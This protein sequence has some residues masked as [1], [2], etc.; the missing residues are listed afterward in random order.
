MKPTCWVTR[1][2]CRPSALGRERSIQPGA[3]TSRGTTSARGM[4]R[5]SGPPNRRR[6]WLPRRLYD[7]PATP[8]YCGP[9][10]NG[11]L[12]KVQTIPSTSPDVGWTRCC[13]A[14]VPKR[15]RPYVA[16][17]GTSLL[18]RLGSG[19]GMLLMLLAL[20]GYFLASLPADRHPSNPDAAIASARPLKAI[21]N[22][23][24]GDW[25]LAHDP[26]LSPSERASASAS[27][28]ALADPKSLRVI[29][30]EMPEGEGEILRVELLR[31]EAWLQENRDQNTLWLQFDELGIKGWATI[32]AVHP[33]PSFA[34]R[35]KRTRTWSPAGSCTRRQCPM[36]WPSSTTPGAGRN[37]R[38]HREPSVL[39]RG[40]PGLRPGRPTAAWRTPARQWA[41][42]LR[43]LP[44]RPQYHR[45]RLQPRS[46]RRTRLPRWLQR[47]PGA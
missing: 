24:L 6:C 9:P 33:A 41:D 30:A 42:A 44:H 4:D 31:T 3:R 5:R 47:H 17:P 23:A 39:E 21:E 7:G 43:P 19:V 8:L 10:L 15:L 40:P 36:I 13:R 14:H 2:T 46:G 27:S 20:L 37:D 35:R 25:V 1:T 12:P 32:L 34:R 11:P 26:G 28:I 38:H 18:A 45:T 16:R 29:S 22:V